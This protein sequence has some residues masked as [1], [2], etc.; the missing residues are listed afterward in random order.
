MSK[1]LGSG[2][3]DGISGYG[4]YEGDGG[5]D[6]DDGD[7][8]GEIAHQGDA[9]FLKDGTGDGSSDEGNGAG[10]GAGYRGY[11]YVCTPRVE[12][13]LL[14]RVINHLVRAKPP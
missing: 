6:L 12:D 11:T 2:F 9:V 1:F 3:G 5:R 7:G 14:G 10:D 8:D 4:G 13:S